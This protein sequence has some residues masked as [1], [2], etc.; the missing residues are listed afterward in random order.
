MIVGEALPAQAGSFTRWRRF[1]RLSISL[2]WDDARAMEIPSQ[3]IR[4]FMTST[5]QTVTMETPLLR[6]S[7]IMAEHRIR[8]LPILDDDKLVG[9]VSERE[10]GLL[11]A[12]QVIDLRVLSIADAMT[13]LPYSV[14]PDAPVSEVCNTMAQNKYGSAV[15][16][17]DGVILGIFTTTDALQIL[18]EVF[19]ALP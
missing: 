2:A 9:V 5:P 3:P 19:R 15:I 8:H 17:E 4:D 7:Q 6:A 11:K 18:A 12:C 13:E 1:C 16:I 14:S 10:I